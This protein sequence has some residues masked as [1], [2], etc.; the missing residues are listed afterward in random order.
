MALGDKQ[1][2]S[3]DSRIGHPGKDGMAAERRVQRRGVE[4]RQKV[5]RAAY[6][7]VSD[8]P[9]AEVQISQIAQ[10]AG[11]NDTTV[12]YYYPSKLAIF[13]ATLQW[14]EEQL[15]ARRASELPLLAGPTERL[16]RLISIYLPAGSHDPTWKLWFESWMRADSDPAISQATYPLVLAWEADFVAVAREG[17]A[18][19]SF[20]LDDPEEYF[21]DFAAY[22][23]GLA[24]QLLV[25]QVSRPAL[26]R[27]A[28][29]RAARDMG[30][31]LDRMLP[32]L[33]LDPR[34]PTPTP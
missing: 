15:A 17:M 33:H 4:A 16:A 22:M 28:L 29:V 14:A 30:A 10:R 6:E 11:M 5:L 8:G 24:V 19:G 1:S 21:G 31:D 25:G 32:E 2:A 18:D 23:A 12:L 13:I 27:R 7:V 9:L 26:L 3:L 34:T 20:T